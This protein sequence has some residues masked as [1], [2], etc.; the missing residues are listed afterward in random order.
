MSLS[1]GML[2]FGSLLMYAGWKNKSVGALARG[3]NT[4][5]KP[6]VTAGAAQ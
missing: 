6:I 1:F 2:L 4:T 3:D 5:T